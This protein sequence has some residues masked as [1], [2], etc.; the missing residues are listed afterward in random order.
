MA[1]ISI[2]EYRNANDDFNNAME[3]GLHNKVVYSFKAVA[4][5]MLGEQELAEKMFDKAI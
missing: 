1:Y 3:A 5:E 2:G 4:L